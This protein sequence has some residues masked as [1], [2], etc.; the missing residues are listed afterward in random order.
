MKVEEFLLN[1]KLQNA[2]CKFEHMSVYLRKYSS[3]ILG[4]RV[5]IANM[6]THPK[7]QASGQFKR[8]VQ[9]IAGTVALC[10]EPVTL[11]VENVLNEHLDAHLIKRGWA[12]TRS[13]LGSWPPSYTKPASECVSYA[14]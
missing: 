9:L 2:W 7:H 4:A 3:P 5:D 6:D 14:K 12:V 13:A 8:L 1:P 10:P 11:Y